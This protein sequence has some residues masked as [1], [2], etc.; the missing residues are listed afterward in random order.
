[1]LQDRLDESYLLDGFNTLSIRDNKL[2]LF[3]LLYKLIRCNTVILIP[4][5]RNL[6]KFFP[7]VYKLS[8]IIN[9]DIIQLCVGGW[10]VDFFT[11]R[12]KWPAHR[13]QM[14]MSKKC[15]AFLPEINKVNDELKSICGFSNCEV[16]PNFRRHI[17][18]LSR[19]NQSVDLRLV[20]LARINQ[21]KGFQTVF[22]L[23]EFIQKKQLNISITFFGKVEEKDKE[24]FSSLL[25]AY[26]DIVEYKG[27][28]PTENIADTLCNYD[29][30][31]FPTRYYTEGFPGTVLDAY[32]SGIPVIA[33]AWMH[34]REFIEDGV[35]GFIVPF[36][37]P[38]NEFNKRVLTLYN[39]RT[40]LNKMKTASRE[41]VSLYSEEKAWAVL[42]KYLKN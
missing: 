40:L 17:P 36:D 42:E 31:L 13:K 10:Q 21:E 20:W 25:E 2:L 32:I 9:Y 7:I 38:Q 33:T 8:K 26:K 35:S 23:A 15:K 3:I 14:E 4:A 1:M 6:E 37:N 16:F 30:M 34:A 19:V 39:D 29:I 22:N 41:R 12:G 5:D 28:L 18:E 24:H 11:G 27:Q